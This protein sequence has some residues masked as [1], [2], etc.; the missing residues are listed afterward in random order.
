MS[1]VWRGAISQSH[2]KHLNNTSILATTKSMVKALVKKAI[3]MGIVQD[4]NSDIYEYG[5][6]DLLHSLFAWGVFLIAGLCINMFWQMCLFMLMHIPF[7]IY[8][9]GLHFATRFRCF[10]ASV[11]IF[12]VVFTL[13]CLFTIQKLAIAMMCLLIPNLIITW[14]LAPVEDLRKPLNSKERK[15]HRK[16]SLAICFVGVIASVICYLLCAYQATYFIGAAI[17][18]VASQLVTGKL[19][20]SVFRFSIK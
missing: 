9:G 7:R 18:V 11:I 6:E 15:H 8:A 20:N 5:V 19:K 2:Q 12:A 10:C 16:V 14:L 4:E 17:M 13:P 3:A 1:L